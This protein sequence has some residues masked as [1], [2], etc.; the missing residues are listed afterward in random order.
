MYLA[1]HRIYCSLSK[2]VAQSWG[3]DDGWGGKGGLHRGGG[4]ACDPFSWSS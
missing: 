2:G 4:A 3:E 1:Y